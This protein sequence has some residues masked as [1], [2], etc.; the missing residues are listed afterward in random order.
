[1]VLNTGKTCKLHAE[2]PGTEP[3][4]GCDVILATNTPHPVHALL[5]I[6]KPTVLQ[7]IP[8]FCHNKMSTRTALNSIF[9]M[10]DILVSVSHANLMV[11]TLTSLES[12]E[13]LR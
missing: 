3:F 6:M 1:M 13:A 12:G 5:E 8:G 7:N 2:R 11:S 9:Y 4:N 10:S